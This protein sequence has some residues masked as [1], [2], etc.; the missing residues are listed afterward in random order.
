MRSSRVVGASDCQC[1]SRNSLLGSIPASSDTVESKGRQKKQ[2]W[3]KYIQ[4][5]EKNPVWKLKLKLSYGGGVQCLSPSTPVQPSMFRAPRCSSPPGQTHPPL[6]CISAYTPGLA[7]LPHVLYIWSAYTPSFVSLLTPPIPVYSY[8]V[9]KIRFTYSQKWNC[10][11]LFPTPTFMYLCAIY[12]F[13]GSV[14]LFGCSKRGRPILVIFNSLKDTR[15]W[16]LGDRTL[17]F[18]FGNN[19]AMQFHFW[20]YMNRNQTYVFDSHP[21][22]LQCSPVNISAYISST[23]GLSWVGLSVFAPSHESLSTPRLC[24]PT[25]SFELLTRGGFFGPSMQVYFF[26]LRSFDLC[27]ALGRP[28]VISLNLFCVSQHWRLAA[29]GQKKASSYS[30]AITRDTPKMEREKDSDPIHLINIWTI[31]TVDRTSG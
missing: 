19:E 15:M 14:C 17:K 6:L 13:Q 5:S 26:N 24:I 1:R 28:P 2:R 9:P 10:V 31:G 23:V 27:L 4:K 16:Q 21:H 12:I 11:A 30:L 18:C 8:T 20:E 22:H 3:I 7:F 25:S 29:I